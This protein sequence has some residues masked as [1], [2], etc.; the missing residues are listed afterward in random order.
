MTGS[1]RLVSDEKVSKFYPHRYNEYG[2]KLA[3]GILN[4][5][6]EHFHILTLKRKGQKL[7]NVH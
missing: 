1:V 6:S 7:T 5:L 3:K 2:R 4:K